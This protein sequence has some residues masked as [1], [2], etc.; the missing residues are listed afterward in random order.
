MYSANGYEDIKN[1]Y[2]DI[3]EQLQN[4]VEKETVNSYIQSVAVVVLADI[5]MNRVFDF[6]FNENDSIE[7]GLKILDQ[8]KEEKDI[9]EVERGKQIFEDW[10]II[11]DSKFVRQQLAR[12]YDSFENKNIVTEDIE[13]STLEMWGMYKDEIYYILPLK[14]NELMRNNSLSP[15]KIRRRICRKRLYKS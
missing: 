12:N 7:L 6:G 4:K 10:L 1:R 5:L 8:L 3:E 13:H 15:N 14:F 11:N 2:N 9:D